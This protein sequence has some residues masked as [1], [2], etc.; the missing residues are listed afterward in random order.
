M[1]WIY[2]GMEMDLCDMDLYEKNPRDKGVHQ[3]RCY[4][5][6]RS[7]QQGGAGGKCEALGQSWL[8]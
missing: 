6:P 8:Q 5:G 1:K 3:E 4:A 7:H 2:E